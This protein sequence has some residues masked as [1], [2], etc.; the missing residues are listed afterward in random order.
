MRLEGLP[1]VVD[2]MLYAWQKKEIRSRLGE[3]VSAI[4]A[5]R[6]DPIWHWFDGQMTGA[7]LHTELGKSGEVECTIH[8]LGPGFF[9]AW[10]MDD[11]EGYDE[12]PQEDREWIL[13]GTEDLALV[14]EWLALA[15]IDRYNK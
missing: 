7:N 11:Y 1:D 9:S 6:Q 14:R 12:I 5:Y 4:P 10:V 2:E 8:E 15:N 13:V 3:R